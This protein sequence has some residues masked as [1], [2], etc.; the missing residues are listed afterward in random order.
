LTDSMCSDRAVPGPAGLRSQSRIG[1]YR[2]RKF[3]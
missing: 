1:R 3:F 2:C